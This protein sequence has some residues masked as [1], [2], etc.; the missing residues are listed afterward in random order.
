MSEVAGAFPHVYFVVGD[1]SRF[2]MFAFRFVSVTKKT[3]LTSLIALYFITNF[4]Y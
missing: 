1:G 2:S 3:M 4:N